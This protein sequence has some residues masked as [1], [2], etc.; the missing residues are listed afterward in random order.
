[1]IPCQF[2]LVTKTWLTNDQVGLVEEE[3]LQQSMFQHGL[4]TTKS[5]PPFVEDPTTITL[6]VYRPRA[7]THHEQHILKRFVNELLK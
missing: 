1:M 5:V 7:Y 6:L 4:D 3:V 2:G